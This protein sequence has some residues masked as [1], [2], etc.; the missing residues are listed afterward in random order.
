MEALGE[1]LLG[2]PSDPGPVAVLSRSFA[3]MEYRKMRR[4]LFG[5]YPEKHR[6]LVFWGLAYFL[7]LGGLWGLD[8]AGWQPAGL[9]L[10]WS[11]ARGPSHAI[12]SALFT[13][14]TL[15]TVTKTGTDQAQIR[16]LLRFEP[17]TPAGGPPNARVRPRRRLLPLLGLRCGDDPPHHRQPARPAAR[18]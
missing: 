2:S 7:V 9:T 15:F 10:Q 8:L 6:I 12:L 18:G 11:S 3:H 16:L 4:L 1:P 13:C 5:L 14:L 17:T